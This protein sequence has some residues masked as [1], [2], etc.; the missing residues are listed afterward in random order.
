MNHV[1]ESNQ[2]QPMEVEQ[3]KACCPLFSGT[4][5]LMFPQSGFNAALSCIRAAGCSNARVYTE[6]LNECSHMC[7]RTDPKTHAANQKANVPDNGFY[8]DELSIAKDTIQYI[9][10]LFPT[11]GTRNVPQFAASGSV[12]LFTFSA[13]PGGARAGLGPALLGVAALVY[14]AI[15]H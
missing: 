10:P 6:L 13:A 15:A 5:K 11:A 7:D 4:G 12:C 3:Q 9:N 14:L 2:K 8:D 1:R